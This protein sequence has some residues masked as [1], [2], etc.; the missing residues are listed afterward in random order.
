[1]FNE[2]KIKYWGY[3]KPAC[4]LTLF[5]QQLYS[6][7]IGV[8]QCDACFI[9]KN[10]AF[11]RWKFASFENNHSEEFPGG[12]GTLY[13][14]LRLTDE[15]M[16]FGVENRVIFSRRSRNIFT[17]ATFYGTF[18]VSSTL[19]EVVVKKYIKWISCALGRSMSL[20]TLQ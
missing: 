14:S 19:Q 13:I 10:L 9:K 1:M 12:G 5:I 2:R 15:Q 11:N 7:Q 3:Y 17:V 8:S 16:L 4:G 20:I 6:C 18:T